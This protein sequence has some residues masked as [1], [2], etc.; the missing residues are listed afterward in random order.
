MVGREAHLFQEVLAGT[1]NVRHDFL[2]AEAHHQF[3]DLVGELL[4]P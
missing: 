2:K 1:Q 3:A 4:D